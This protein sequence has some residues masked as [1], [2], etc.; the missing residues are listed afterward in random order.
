MNT[1]RVVVLKTVSDVLARGSTFITF[2]IFAAHAGADGYGA[3]VQAT[4][5]VAFIAPF[6]TLGLASAVIRFFSHSGWDRRHAGLAIRLTMIVCGLSSVGALLLLVF[7]DQ[8]NHLILDWPLGTSL[9]KWASLLVIASS[10]EL[11]VLELL[12]ARQKLGIYSICQLLHTILLLVSVVWLVTDDQGVIQLLI[13]LS[14]I[15]FVVSGGASI[16]LWMRT[17]SSDVP[18]VRKLPVPFRQMVGFGLP[19]AISGLG[20]WFMNLGDRLVIGAQM[21]A[22]ALGRYAA[23]FAISSLLSLAGSGF[24]FPALPRLMRSGR[25]ADVGTLEYEVRT[26]HRYLSMVLAPGVVCLVLIGRPT[27]ELLGGTSFRASGLLLVL[28]LVTPFLD[29][30]NALAHYILMANDRTR[31]IQYT[32]LGCGALNL[33]LNLLVVPIWGLPGSAGVTVLSFVALEAILFG[34]AM[35]YVDLR[36]SYAFATTARLLMLSAAVAVA[37]WVTLRPQANVASLLVVGAAYWALV[38]FGMIVMRVIVPA[39]VDRIKR[40][41]RER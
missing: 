17:R 40:L 23:V 30:W 5:L 24:L 1:G 29:Q 27:L 28:M 33:L 21:S 22:D 11:M 20:L 39:D 38:L 6:L 18:D 8:V 2:P 19:L 16:F 13:A 7:A 41:V 10:M 25:S 37:I 9:F 14:I 3:Y 4:S 35:R 26:F 12:R 34:A 31:L 15:K 32:W 36:S